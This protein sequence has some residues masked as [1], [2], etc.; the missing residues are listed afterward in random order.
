MK[1]I[2]STLFVALFIL[3]MG[4]DKSSNKQTIVIEKG[5]V[6]L[7]G[8]GSLMS[9]KKTEEVFKHKYT[10]SIYLVHLQGFQ[11]TWDFVSSNADKGYTTEELKN[12]GYYIRGK[13]TLIFDNSIF[14]N[15]TE[16][17]GSEMNGVMYMVTGKEIKDMDLYEFGYERIDVTDKIKEYDFEGGKVYA[18]KATP[19]YLFDAKKTKGVTIIHQ[20]YLDL[21]TKACDS[22]GQNFRKEYNASTSSKNLELV[23]PVV[24]KKVR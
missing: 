14:L 17:K 15:I 23:A 7:I 1:I 8:F 24:W 13:D 11:R 10:D 3:I 20:D 21:V 2:N 4:C 19:E 12:D 9:L 5:K 6:G 18:Y 16:Q 22:I